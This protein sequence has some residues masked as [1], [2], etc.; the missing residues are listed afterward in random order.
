MDRAP[1]RRDGTIRFEID[2]GD[3]RIESE[4]SPKSSIRDIREIMDRKNGP[5]EAGVY[6]GKTHRKERPNSTRSNTKQQEVREM[7]ETT[8]G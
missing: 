1:T 8:V 6:M 4:K 5:P 2:G 3:R 7:E